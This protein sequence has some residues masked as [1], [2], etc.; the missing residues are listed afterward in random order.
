[1]LTLTCCICGREFEISNERAEYVADTL[2]FVGHECPTCQAHFEELVGVRH[3]ETLCL[4][5]EALIAAGERYCIKCR[6]LHEHPDTLH[7]SWGRLYRGPVDGRNVEDH[8]RLLPN[9]DY[10]T[11]RKARQIVQAWSPRY[12]ASSH[13]AGLS[14]LFRH[15][16]R[17]R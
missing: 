3:A 7:D 16:S 13:P 17:F 11:M 5:C 8:E 4:N 1:M 14:E 12:E 6:P 15:I 10:E 2:D 9:H